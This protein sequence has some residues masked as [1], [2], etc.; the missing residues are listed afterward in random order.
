MPS[1]EVNALAKTQ[2]DGINTRADSKDSLFASFRKV[3]PGYRGFQ[4]ASVHN[5]RSFKAADRTTYGAGNAAMSQ[6]CKASGGLS[7]PQC[8]GES[9]IIKE[10]F[11]APLD[12]RPSDNGLTN[13]QLFYQE[14]RPFEGLPRVHYPNARH[15]IGMKFPANSVSSMK[16]S[17]VNLVKSVKCA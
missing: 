3:L 13:A 9:L 12:G 7:R 10:M 2:A 11:T 4:P 8:A 15:Q 5:S 6:C 14:I 16:D 1:S 17:G